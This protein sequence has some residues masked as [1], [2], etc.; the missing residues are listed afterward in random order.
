MPIQRRR[1]GAGLA[2]GL[3][4]AKTPTAVYLSP[5]HA[6]LAVVTGYVNLEVYRLDG[7]LLGRKLG[8]H[9]VERLPRVAWSD[10]GTALTFVTADEQARVLD[11]PSG[12]SRNLGRATAVAFFPGGN[13]IAARQGHMI[14]IHD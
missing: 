5:D 9:P 12:N 1:A 10:S 2:P 13:R 4:G 8:E 11:I 7:E 14:I 6:H 3:T